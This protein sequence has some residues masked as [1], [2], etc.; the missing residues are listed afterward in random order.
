MKKNIVL[1]GDSKGLGLKT[2]HALE[3][4]GY[5]VIGISRN[6]K[7]IK[8]D[9]SNVDQIKSLYMNELKP[10]GPIH[11]FVN[12]AA[13]AYDDLA[14]NMQLKKLKSMFE[15]N[16]FSPMLLTK[17]ILRDMLLN[18]IKGSIVHVSSIS[19]HTGYKG[20]SMY[21][22]TKGA[23]ESFSKNISRE[24]GRIGV[25]SN[26]V[27]PGFI[28]T[29]M[30]EKIDDSQRAKIFN[31][32]SLLKELKITDVSS[33]ILFLVSCQSEGITGQVIHVDNGTL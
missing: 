3:S 23:L 29:E 15:V 1:T 8:Y 17:Y 5:N 28:D 16:V 20:L 2:R 27:C 10:R 26:I 4:N 14:T 24:W 12:N 11:G 32:N 33:T 31:R 6:S 7:D 9:F 21:A 19:A 25:R 22:S 30:S 13:F 18:K